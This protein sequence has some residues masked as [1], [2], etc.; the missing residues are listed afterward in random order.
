[1]ADQLESNTVT[2]R[3]TKDGETCN[4]KVDSLSGI[5]GLEELMLA[6]ANNNNNDPIDLDIEGGGL[7]YLADWLESS[8]MEEKNR[9]IF[10]RNLFEEMDGSDMEKFVQIL[11]ELSFPKEDI[12]LFLQ[13]MNE[14]LR[15]FATSFQLE[16]HGH[17]NV[18]ALG[19]IM[20]VVAD[21]IS[22]KVGAGVV[23]REDNSQS[24]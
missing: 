5:S 24:N 12:K 18:K 20:A 2:L 19:N 17:G 8:Q 22:H 10:L 11:K 3:S 4:V 23:P 1:M 7:R 9:Y 6:R 15:G 16:G 14:K 13:L 21:I